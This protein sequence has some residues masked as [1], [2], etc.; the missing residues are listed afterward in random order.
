MVQSILVQ[1]FPLF[2]APVFVAPMATDGIFSDRFH[3]LPVLNVLGM[4]AGFEGD[5]MVFADIC[6]DNISSAE[7]SYD[8]TDEVPGVMATISMAS[9]GPSSFPQGSQGC[10]EY[11]QYETVESV[12][13]TYVGALSPSGKVIW[14]I[15]VT[16]TDGTEYSTP[17]FRTILLANEESAQS[18]IEAILNDNQNVFVDCYQCPV[19]LPSGTA[20]EYDA[21]G[22]FINGNGNFAIQY[23]G[24][25]S[26]SVL[27]EMR[28]FYEQIAPNNSFY[29]LNNSALDSLSQSVLAIIQ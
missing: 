26:A 4:E 9:A 16:H 23:E 25:Y 29:V 6:T 19:E 17:L 18:A 3:S 24:A 2:L 15:K 1:A 27:N 7:F 21:V 12:P 10:S 5:R 8:T 28:L 14:N 20:V 22:F 11:S 13:L